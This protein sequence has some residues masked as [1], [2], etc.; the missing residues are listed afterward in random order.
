M[1]NRNPIHQPDSTLMIFYQ[2]CPTPFAFPTFP[3]LAHVAS[4]QLLGLYHFQHPNVHHYQPNLDSCFGATLDRYN[5]GDTDTAD[6]RNPADQ[7]RLVVYP[8]IYRV[9][10][11][12]GAGF[13]PS[14]AAFYLQLATSR[15]SNQ[16]YL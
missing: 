14:T 16:D 7:L 10:Y 11:I 9:L 4:T 8:I 6:G 5:N 3:L 1:V 2:N 15:N 12:P 13:L